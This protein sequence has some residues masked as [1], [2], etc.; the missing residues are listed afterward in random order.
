MA[1]GTGISQVES[2]R[3]PLINNIGAVEGLFKFIQEGSEYFKEEPEDA[4]SLLPEYDFII[5]GAGSAGCVIANKLSEIYKWNILLIEAGRQENYLMDIPLLATLFQ[6]T[7]A[8]WNFK[9]EPSDNV[10]LGMDNKQCFYPRGKVVGGSSVINYMIATRGS[11][12]S[13]DNW[14]DMGNTGWRYK[15]LLPYFLQIEDMTIPELAKDKTYHST[16][17]NLPISYAPYRTVLVDAF[18][19]GGK[20]LGYQEVDYNGE[21]QIG[22]SYLQTTTKNG[23]RWSASRA[24]LHPIRKRKNFHL[25]KR[26]Q[27]TKILFDSENKTAYGV[28]FVQN[29]VKYVVHAK[30]EVIISAGAINAPQL[31]MLSGIGPKEHL[32]DIGIPVI[33]DLK[34]GYNLMDHP[35]VIGLAFTVNNSGGIVFEDMFSNG[36]S[37]AEYLNFHTGPLSIPAGCEGLAYFDTTRPVKNGGDPDLEIMFFPGSIASYEVYYKTFGITDHINEVVYKPIQNKHTWNAIPLTLKPRSRGRVMLKSKN[38][39]DKPGIYHNF[40]EDPY[41]LEIQLKGIKKVLEISNTE[42]FQKFGSKL[43]DT[44]VPG[45]EDLKLGSDDYWICYIKHLSIAIWHLSGTCKMGPPS[46]PGAVVDD[47][48]RVYGIKGLRVADASIMPM[49]PAAHTN[50]PAMVIGMKCAD[51]I[52]KSWGF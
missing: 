52:R 8:N 7:E 22:F 15:D 33:K 16:G 45:C 29:N 40:Y 2:Q 46:D 43:H 31:L 19:E 32:Q 36:N 37:L 11:K 30:R 51:M 48:L 49:V 13:Y 12:E 47:E 5:V 26:S 10:C 21:S 23:T 14:E 38:P 6:L 18:V 44:P 9:T 20:Q 17:G 35:G 1:L 42:A 3:S 4:K 39:F 24:F 25:K 50:I 34:V 28:E 27:V 41:D